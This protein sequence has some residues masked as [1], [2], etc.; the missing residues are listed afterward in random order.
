[1]MDDEEK[2]RLGGEVISMLAGGRREKDDGW[3]KE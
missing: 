3:R 1:M 2:E